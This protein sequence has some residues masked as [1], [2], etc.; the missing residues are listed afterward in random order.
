MDK[1]DFN[2][3]AKMLAL[4]GE[5]YGKTPSPELIEF[6]FDGLE[7]IELSAVREALNRHIRN[8]DTGQFMPKVADILRA[9]S[10]TTTDAAYTALVKLQSAFSAVGAYESPKFDDPIIAAV[11]ADMGGWPEVCGRNA[12]EWQ[13]FGSNEF[14]RRYRSIASR[15]V[16]IEPPLLAGIFDRT[17]TALGFGAAIGRIESKAPARIEHDKETS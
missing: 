14:M 17:N 10:G 2:S 11:V 9:L 1:G 16:E 8:T 3:F 7:H 12:E 15:G 5:Q 6:Y 4:T 13:K